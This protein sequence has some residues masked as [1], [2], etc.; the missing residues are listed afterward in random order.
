MYGNGFND[1]NPFSAAI[2]T[3]GNIY[4]AD[5][6]ANAIALYDV[7]SQT[8]SV[9]DTFP[10]FPNPFGGP[11]PSFDYVPTR[12]ISDQAGGFLLGNLGAFFPGFGRI[13]SV[14][15]NGTT[16]VLDTGLTAVVDI[17]YDPVTGNRYALQ[18]GEFDSVFNPVM[19]SAK[20]YRIDPLGTVDMLYSGF[21]P[22]SGFV[23]DGS[24]GAYVTE[25]FTGN[26][27]YFADISSAGNLPKPSE[28]SVKAFPSPFTS[29]VNI[30]VEQKRNVAAMLIIKNV[31]G[32]TVYSGE[33]KLT[34]GVN[35]INWNG[36]TTGGNALP[37]GNYFLTIKTPDSSK[38]ILIQKQ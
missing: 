24:G 38:T 21:G 32:E 9:L 7:G 2:G 11:P 1:S 10:P 6:G 19:G 18:F 29:T 37:A 5:A 12:I 27:L 3:N 36:T 34:N 28:L 17:Q 4:V 33:R 35:S 8:F 26:V 22:S 30:E 31:S 13:I 15:A 23:L 14:D 20:I 25:I 16:T